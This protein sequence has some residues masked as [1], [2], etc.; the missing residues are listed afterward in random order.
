MTAPMS[1]TFPCPHCGAQYPR[2]PVLVG[3]TVRCTSCKNAFILRDNGIADKVQ[4]APL[5]VAAPTPTPE[6]PAR[7]SASAPEV[8]SPS[9]SAPLPAISGPTPAASPSTSLPSRR[10]LTQKAEATRRAMAAT[11]SDAMSGALA[12]ESVK[13]DDEKRVAEEKRKARQQ[14]AAQVQA[15]LILANQ[16]THVLA[17]GAVA[18]LIDL[19]IHKG[20]ERIG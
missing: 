18:A 17:A 10:A 7:P 6:A 11:L 8:S 2:K 5:P 19:L 12:A 16:L 13:R 1:G 4:P 15:I 20:L 9:P 14:E 3:K